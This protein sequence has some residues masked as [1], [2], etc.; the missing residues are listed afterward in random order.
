[1]KTFTKTLLAIITLL[2]NFNLNAAVITVSNWS[3]IPAQFTSVQ[4]AI[5]AANA[6]D[7]IY[8]H[9]SPTSYGTIYILKKLTIIGAGFY[10]SGQNQNKS[11][12]NAV[13]LQPKE[14]AGIDNSALIG[15]QSDYIYY[16]YYA[17]PSGQVFYNVREITIDRCYFANLSSG[18]SSSTTNNSFVIK[19]CFI[20]GP[21][22]L[23]G[24]TDIS[25]ANN[26]F[27]GSGSI[28]GASSP[29]L[30][31]IIFQNA[32]IGGFYPGNLVNPS[33]LSYYG[34]TTSGNTL[35]TLNNVIFTNNIFYGVPLNP[36][37]TNTVF[38]NNI[39]FATNNDALVFPGAIT[40]GTISSN[41]NFVQMENPQ[42][43]ACQ[44]YNSIHAS[45]S[46]AYFNQINL[47]LAASSPAINTG[48]GGVNIGPSGGVSEFNYRTQ[49]RPRIPQMQSLIINNAGI[50]LG[51]TLNVQIQGQKQD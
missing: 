37:L 47:T 9:G 24:V 15:I 16:Q 35:G 2:L 13:Y 43:A 11:K 18:Y 30:N 1:M 42:I 14:V 50:P 34:I 20:N 48:I 32:F 19:N 40:T 33:C 7:T 8:V 27:I 45:L 44:F 25:I 51:G 38:N 10:T 12:F 36:S 6:N 3:V 46:E 41:P 31:A 39:A 26:Y 49:S 4:D 28:E 23:I 17:D 22:N 5:V 29:A 21:I